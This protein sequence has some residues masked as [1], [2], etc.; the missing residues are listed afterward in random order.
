MCIVTSSIKSPGFGFGA[1]IAMCV[2]F[3]PS[4]IQIFG[5]WYPT[6][7]CS[8]PA[9]GSTI[10][11]FFLW[12]GVFWVGTG[13]H[14]LP[15]PE[16]W[17]PSF[18]RLE[19][20]GFACAF[21]HLFCLRA[22]IFMQ[23]SANMWSLPDCLNHL[24]CAA[25]LPQ[26]QGLLLVP[27]K[28][29]HRSIWNPF[30]S[31]DWMICLRKVMV[32]VSAWFKKMRAASCLA[33]TQT[34]LWQVFVLI[35]PAGFF[36]WYVV[37]PLFSLRVVFLLF[38]I[39]LKACLVLCLRGHSCRWRAVCSSISLA[40]LSSWWAL[41]TRGRT[42]SKMFHSLHHI[43]LFLMLEKKAE[44]MEAG[45]LPACSRE[46]CCKKRRRFWAAVLNFR[47]QNLQ[48]N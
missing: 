18:R 42:S 7:I 39:Q 47:F 43:P 4:K 44:L 28:W 5:W 13:C 41:A 11:T 8:I 14:F 10:R 31:L 15:K 22:V 37:F 12:L 29:N 17:P 38:L 3:V 2:R 34:L 16:R 36:F 46:G 25:G 40:N 45:K 48:K 24:Q 6:R 30:V 33:W 35:A 19:L 1:E 20:I 27:W 21:V 32:M 9:A 23:S 26:D